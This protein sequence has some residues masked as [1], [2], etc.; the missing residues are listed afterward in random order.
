M[1]AIVLAYRNPKA[2]PAITPKDNIVGIEDLLDGLENLRDANP[3][4]AEVAVRAMM[5]VLRTFSG[6]SRL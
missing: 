2:T 4:A 3:Y 6:D 5:T 1:S